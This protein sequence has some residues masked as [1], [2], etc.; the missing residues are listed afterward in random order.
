M[1]FFFLRATVILAYVPQELLGTSFYEYCHED[2]IAHLAE[3]HRQGMQLT[4]NIILNCY[5]TYLQ[6]R[7]ATAVHGQ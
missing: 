5:F 4:F 6:Y 2:D 1:L 7:Y 3:C